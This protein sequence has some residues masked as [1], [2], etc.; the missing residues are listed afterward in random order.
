M[1]L[2]L[3]YER[4]LSECG[5]KHLALYRALRDGIAA[6]TLSPGERLPSTRQLASLYGL[7]RGSVSL[8]YE[9]LAAEGY[10]RAGVGQGTF[11]S[12]VPGAWPSAAAGEPAPDAAGRERSRSAPDTPALSA[13]GFRVMEQAEDERDMPAPPGGSGVLSFFPR[14]MG[15]KWFPWMEWRSRVAAQ[16][17]RLGDRPDEA[18]TTEGSLE[19]RRAIAGRLR[20]ERGIVCGPEDVVVTGGSMQA[21]AL[22]TQLLLEEGRTA[23]VEDPCYQGTLRAVKATGAAL[24]A[25]KVDGEGIVPQDWDADLLFVTP[26]RQFPT[27]AVLKLERRLE[28]LDWASRKRAWIVED[29]YDSDFRW[30]GRP[31][32]PLKSLD[33]EGRV[34][35]VGSFSRTMRPEVR[36]GYAVLP[37]SLRTPFVR[38][39]SLY[40]PHPEGIAEQHALSEWMTDGGY[41]RHLRRMRRIFQRLQAKLRQGLAEELG[42]LFDVVP[43]DAGLLLFAYWKKTPNDYDRLA[44][45]CRELGVWWG[46]G[47]R[48]AVEGGEGSD[49]R[50]AL[51]GFAHMNEAEVE[52]GLARIRRAAA[53]LGLSA[54]NE[55]QGGCAHA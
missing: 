44:L 42:D 4:M 49:R 40:D 1:T 9:M 12:G 52:E 29:D 13:W 54:C 28:L 43:S 26:T 34:I 2:Q 18:S 23:V 33:R 45:R 14:G 46:D 39:K 38:A 48:Y 31:I 15:E 16:W 21:I 53:S 50:S 8:A 10:V 36:I 27:G 32:E 22:L 30:G 24:V 55:D 3:P 6:G 41:D 51:F 5:S 7:S 20:R 25:A 35:Y 37:R 19:L 11:V 17:K 47:R